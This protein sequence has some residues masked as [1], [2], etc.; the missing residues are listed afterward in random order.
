M[1]ESSHLIPQLE[2]EIPQLQQRLNEEEKVLEQIKASSLE[3]VERLRAELTQVRTELEPWENQV[4]EHKGRLG[5]ASAEKNLMKQ[6]HDGAQAELTDAQNQMESI[7]EKVKTKDSYIV[8]LQ[9]KIDKHQNEASES[10]KIEQECQ[11]Q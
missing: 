4:I 7:K 6:K 1:E 5:V 3:E 9:E 11:K 10:R 8:E 2:A